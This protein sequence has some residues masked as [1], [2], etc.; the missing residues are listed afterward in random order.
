MA[1]FDEYRDS[2][3]DSINDA[4]SFSG[5]SLD[6][7]T[8]AKAEYLLEVLDQELP[9]REPLEVLDVGCGLGDVHDH[10]LGGAPALELTGIDVAA[11]VIDEA[12]AKDRAIRYDVYDGTVLPYTDATFDAA[13]TIC[14]MH[15]VPPSQWQA[16]LKEMRRVVRP[17]GAVVVFEHNPLNPL[18]RRVV[19]DCP[20]DHNAVLLRARQLSQ[21]CSGVG[22]EKVLHRFILFTPFNSAA[23]K[24]FDRLMGW[25]PL[26]AQ[27]FVVGRVPT[28]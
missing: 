9:D 6:F 5:Q 11:T 27:Y 7:F 2:Y 10:L 21:L 1:E 4:V 13:Y 16:F 18:T 3:R 23:F 20:I 15:H 17:G 12:R 8:K 19:K 25:L 22:L 24:R 26:G 14:V 28:T